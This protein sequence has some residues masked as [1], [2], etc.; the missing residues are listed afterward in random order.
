MSRTTRFKWHYSRV[1]LEKQAE[2]AAIHSQRVR[3][4]KDS[5]LR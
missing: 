3:T 1:S 5:T 4:A 2:E